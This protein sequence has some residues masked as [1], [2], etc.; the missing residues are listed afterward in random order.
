LV[1]NGAG[2]Q[3]PR[4]LVVSADESVLKMVSEVLRTHG[5][6]VRTLARIERGAFEAFLPDAVL[7]D[8]PRLSA[9]DES[10][11]RAIDRPLIA[12]AS[13]PHGSSRALRLGARSFWPLPLDIEPFLRAVRAACGADPPPLKSQLVYRGPERR[14]R[15]RPEVGDLKPCPHCSGAI[16]FYELPET[17]AA[18]IC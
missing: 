14:A 7:A 17:G 5:Y 16:R 9:G 2:V 18:W 13:L 10:A 4:V 1:A 12:L 6:E 11:L 15:I 3:L 8:T